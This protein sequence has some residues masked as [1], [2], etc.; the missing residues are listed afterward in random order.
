QLE[1]L[2]QK[3]GRLKR[4]IVERLRQH[5]RILEPDQKIDPYRNWTAK[6]NDVEKALSDLADLTDRR[7]IAERVKRLLQSHPPKSNKGV[8]ARVS[9]LSTALNLAP[10]VSEEFALD[11][12]AQ[13]LPAYDGLSEAKDAVVLEQRARLLEKGLFVAAHFDRKDTVQAMV[14]RFASLL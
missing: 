4:Y 6:I 3:A 5:S 11:M 12:L 8:E 1:Q 9:I 14:G 2:D 13:L 10:R 7:E